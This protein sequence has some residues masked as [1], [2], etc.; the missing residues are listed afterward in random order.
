MDKTFLIR[1]L[2]GVGITNSWLAMSMSPT[3]A[4]DVE[5]GIRVRSMMAPTCNAT[6]EGA[7]L[8]DGTHFQG[9]DWTNRKQL[10]N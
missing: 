10:D 3:M 5:G 9:C 2:N 8:Y 1:S 4:L 7:I 6:K